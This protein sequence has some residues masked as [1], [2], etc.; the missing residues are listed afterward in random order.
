MPQHTVACFFQDTVT[1][2]Q[3][4]ALAYTLE[5]SNLLSHDTEINKQQ[6]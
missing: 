1:F 3:T 5:S 6:P 2:K 4:T